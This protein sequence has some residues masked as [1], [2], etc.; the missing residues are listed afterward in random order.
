MELLA[1][2]SGEESEACDARKGLHGGRKLSEGPMEGLTPES[3]S[4]VITDDATA[5]GASCS[6]SCPSAATVG[7]AMTD[8]VLVSTVTTVQHV[9]LTYVHAFS[10][11]N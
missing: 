9:S 7:L 2:R 5:G 6:I 11:N 3:S 10:N 8:S 1:S 4:Q